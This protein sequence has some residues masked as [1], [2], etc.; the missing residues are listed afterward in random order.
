MAGNSNVAVVEALFDAFARRDPEAMIE[1]MSEDVVF[2]P[3]STEQATREPY[4]GHEGIHRYL[5][6][7]TRTWAEFRVT[8][9][10]YRGAGDRVLAVGRVY[11]RSNSPVFISDSEISFVWWLR[12][13][14]I[15]HGRT[16]TDP[17]EAD[18]A[19]RASA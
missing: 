1:L 17:H 12:D 18:A 3:A 7:L 14:R 10:E 13:G 16:Y 9:H 19:L 8:I 6:D 11:A 4:R 15:V 2:E 5:R